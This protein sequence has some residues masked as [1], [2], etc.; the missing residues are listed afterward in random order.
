METISAQL[1]HDP[2]ALDWSWDGKLIAVGDR[3]GTCLLLDA[4]T[5]EVKSTYNGKFAGKKDAWIEDIKFSPDSTRI[6]YGNHGGLSPVEIV[7]VTA[8]KKLKKVATANVGLTSALSHLDWS[9]DGQLLMI[10]SQANELMFIDINSRKQ[11]TASGTKGMD[12]KTMTCLFGWP[13]Q[14]IWPGLDYTD[15]NSVDRSRNQLL[16]ATG[17]DFGQVKL[18][19]YPCVKEKAGF[20]VFH[21]HSSHVTGVKFTANDTF[22]VSTGGNDKT[23]MVWDTDINDD[24]QAY[25]G[26]GAAAAGQVEDDDSDG[27]E[28]EKMGAGD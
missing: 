15:V 26:G 5:L 20:N 24:D 14:G 7:E 11:V 2:T 27:F 23:V 6:A 21:G 3:N 12:Y 25:F 13:V 9:I 4:Q 16:L 17:D 19:K 28:E 1:T 18:F 22:V 10:N 8:Q